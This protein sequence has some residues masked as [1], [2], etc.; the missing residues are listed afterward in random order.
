M[1]K[2]EGKIS[3]IIVMR[4]GR[5]DDMM[6]CIKQACVEKGIKN[7]VILS[8]V[9]SLDGA[10]YG[11]PYK[12]PGKKCGIS[13]CEPIYLKSPVQVLSAHGEVCHNESGEISVHIHATFVSTDGKASGGHLPE[14]GNRVLNTLNIFIGVVDGVDM[15]FEWDDFLEGPVFSPKNMR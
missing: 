3:G 10:Y 12:D 13:N 14:K 4:L 11:C 7:A 8:I 2:A 9:G 5:G 6:E 15:G 1:K